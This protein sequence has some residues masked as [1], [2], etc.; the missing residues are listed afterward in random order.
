MTSYQG[1]DDQ[2][3]NNFCDGCTRVCVCLKETGKNLQTCGVTS[4]IKT[5]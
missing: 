3:E 5:V 1:E 2:K 4:G